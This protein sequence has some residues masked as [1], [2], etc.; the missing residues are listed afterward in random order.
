MGLEGH[1]KPIVYTIFNISVG[2]GIV[3]A[4]KAVFSVFNFKFVYALT[5]VHTVVTMVGMWIF[6]AGGI[7]EVKRFKAMEVRSWWQPFC[8]ACAQCYAF[9]GVLGHPSG[10]VR[11]LVP[12]HCTVQALSTML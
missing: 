9:F 4:N 2:C 11:S 8:Q 5:L 12:A 6:A 1:I 10:R 3:F 7:F